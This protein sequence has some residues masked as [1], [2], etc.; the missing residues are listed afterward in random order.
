MTLFDTGL[1]R[2]TDPDTSRTAAAAMSSPAVD[3]CQ[4]VEW[5]ISEIHRTNGRE[6]ATAYEV[7]MRLAYTGYGPAQNSIA[8]R[9]TTLHRAGR[10]VDVGL[11]RRG[12]SPQPLICWFPASEVAP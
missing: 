1:A 5:A 6:G 11:R 10:I 9:C 12:S 8:R 3:L 4:R 7:M 2:A